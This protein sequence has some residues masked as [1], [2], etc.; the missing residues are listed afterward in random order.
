MTLTFTLKRRIEPTCALIE[1][2]F[3]L[4]LYCSLF[5]LIGYIS[6]L[7]LGS[8]RVI[9]AIEGA[10]SAARDMERMSKRMLKR[11]SRDLF[12]SGYAEF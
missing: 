9:H 1:I 5:T 4:N 8:P 3:H 2:V 12:S 7:Q 11:M 10:N 6:H